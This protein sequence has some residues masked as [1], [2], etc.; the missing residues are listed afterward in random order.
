[1]YQ[2]IFYDRDK[3]KMHL[4]DSDAGY[5]SFPYKRYAYALDENGQ[6][7]TIFGDKV[8]K[9]TKWDRDDTEGL[10]ETDINPTT[11]TLVDLYYD[12][13]DD[14]YPEHRTFIIDID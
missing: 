13:P 9:I 1:M 3:F 7:K 2:N 12:S 4:W 14:E 8:S 6:Y 11:R 5:R 10:F